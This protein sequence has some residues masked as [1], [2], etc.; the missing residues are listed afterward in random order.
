MRQAL[1]LPEMPSLSYTHPDP[2]KAASGVVVSRRE[3]AE[4]MACG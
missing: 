4:F 3:L 2:V 1:N